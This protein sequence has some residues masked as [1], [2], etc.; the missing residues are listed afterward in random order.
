L[1]WA[2]VVADGDCA[3]EVVGDAV[4]VRV[5]VGHGADGEGVAVGADDLGESAGDVVRVVAVE[6]VD[7]W[8][9]EW[10]AV[11][12]VDVEDVGDLEAAQDAGGLVVVVVALVGAGGEDGDALFA[13]SDLAAEGLPGAVA[14]DAGGVGALGEDEQEVVQGVGPEPSGGVEEALPVLAI[15][16]VLDGGDESVVRFGESVGTGHVH[17]PR[18]AVPLP[19]RPVPCWRGSH[20][21]TDAV[22]VKGRPKAEREPELAEARSDP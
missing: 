11:G 8:G 3:V 5:S 18:C 10:V 14:G 21:G 13:S 4:G 15:D 7:G 6:E 16:E 19:A 22:G 9:G 20:G 12:L 2:E 17:T 1:R